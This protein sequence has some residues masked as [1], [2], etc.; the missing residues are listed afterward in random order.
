[1]GFGIAGRERCRQSAERRRP[2]RGGMPRSGE[3]TKSLGFPPTAIYAA[4]FMLAKEAFG[5][6]GNGQKTAIRN[7]KFYKIAYI[8]SGLGG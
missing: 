5:G 7:L 8:V 6:K 4:V 1:V 3:T 2:F